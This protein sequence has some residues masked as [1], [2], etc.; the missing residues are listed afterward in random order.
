MDRDDDP[1]IGRPPSTLGGVIRRSTLIKIALLLGSTLL[2]LC[3]AEWV[4]RKVL[5]GENP[6]FAALRDPGKYSD[7]FNEA[8]NWKLYYLFGGEYH[9]P[10]H[11]HPLLGW[12]GDFGPK[13]LMHN[14]IN[15]VHG[16]RPVLLYG[17][18]YAQCMPEV[19]CFQDILNADTAFSRE[20][21]LLNYG[22][23]GFGVDQIA[24]LCENTVQRY[25]RPVVVFSLMTTDLDRTPLDWRTGQKPLFTEVDDALHLTG[26]P[27]DPD[28]AHYIATHGV[29]IR[30]YLWRRF[31]FSNANILPQGATD[32]L[33]SKT[34]HRKEK[35]A[36]NTRIL[37]RVVD[38]LRTRDIPFLFVVFHYLTPEQPEF[39]V[40]R[41]DNWRDQMLRAFLEDR[42]VPYIWSKD[43]I[44]RD[45]AWTGSNLDRYMIMSNGHPTTYL[46]ELIA[47]EMKLM[48]LE[49]DAASPQLNTPTSTATYEQQ[50]K[51]LVAY[52]P[53]DSTWW[54]NVQQHAV[55]DSCSVEARL[56]VEAVW[57]VEQGSHI[58]DEA[59]ERYSRP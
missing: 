10:E 8:D 26:I 47:N 14:R 2:A 13:S 45:P 22:V 25:E 46:N 38:S 9:P 5:F 4:F 48:V 42:H 15:E 56:K 57:S 17:D 23:G 43:V 51:D 32:R 44:R 34:R 31:L 24:L 58:V 49:L 18:S 28:P 35:V 54:R 40:S 39:M 29:G 11:P 30:S 52:I 36:L 27:I 33:L 20:H 1:S 6:A 21:Y 12:I 50:V 16:R 19:S 55:Q 59:I 37:E 41:E 3:M 53:S 7:P